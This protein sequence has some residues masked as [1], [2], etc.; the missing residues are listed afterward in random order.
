[1]TYSL[2]AFKFKKKVF[3]GLSGLCTNIP[4]FIR[5]IQINSRLSYPQSRVGKERSCLRK[6]PFKGKRLFPV[7]QRERIVREKSE[8]AFVLDTTTFT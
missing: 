6:L 4:G 8:I 5:K 3:H 7:R 2:S 1:M